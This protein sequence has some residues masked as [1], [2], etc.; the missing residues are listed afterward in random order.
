MASEFA[1]VVALSTFWIIAQPGGAWI[2]PLV[3]SVTA[4]II[5]SFCTVPIGLDT[6]TELSPPVPGDVS[7]AAARSTPNASDGCGAREATRMAAEKATPSARSVRPRAE[8]LRP[9]IDSASLFHA[10]TDWDARRPPTSGDRA[11]MR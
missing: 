3:L 9:N 1:V 6:I 5:K 2:A 7:E 11:A 4:A 10:S 8:R